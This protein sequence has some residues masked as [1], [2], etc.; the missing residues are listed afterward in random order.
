LISQAEAGKSTR[1]PVSASVPDFHEQ[2]IGEARM[3]GAST[4]AGS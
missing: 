3:T 4:Q 2:R 1:Q